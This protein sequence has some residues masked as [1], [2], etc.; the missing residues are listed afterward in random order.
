[1]SNIQYIF[2]NKVYHVY[3]FGRDS[4]KYNSQKKLNH[5]ENAYKKSFFLYKYLFN[6][7]VFLQ[8]RYAR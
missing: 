7:L 6:I 8:S 2:S 1:M 4:R 3:L 5:K